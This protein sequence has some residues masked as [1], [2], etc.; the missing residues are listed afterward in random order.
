MK[1][2]P[3]TPYHPESPSKGT[4][5]D[6]IHKNPDRFI[7]VPIVITEKLDGSNTLIHQG[8]VYGR[9]VEA[10]STNKW[11][12]MVK[13]HH[14]WKSLDPD[15]FIYGENLFG[16]H[17]IEYDPMIE[18]ET[19]RVFAVRY[20]DFFISF[21]HME[22]YCSYRKMLTV[23][24]IFEGTVNSAKELNK[25]IQNNTTGTSAIGGKE[26]EGL[27][28][29]IREPFDTKDFSDSVCKSVRK[30]HV[31][32]DEHWTKNWKPCKLRS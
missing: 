4:R 28:I 17:S 31:Q 12:A 19:Y 21:D 10:P 18:E 8:E 7:G 14:S 6:R 9:S 22:A 30:N 13:K 27:V 15:T 23:P 3:S 11:M 20:K 32:T 1:K 2:Y 5:A 29:R 25:I 26:R 24:T 16:I